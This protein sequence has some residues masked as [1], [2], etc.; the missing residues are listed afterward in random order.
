MALRHPV[1]T[2]SWAQFGDGE[3]KV[4]SRVAP[5]RKVEFARGVSTR[6]FLAAVA[7]H[8]D[9]LVSAACGAGKSVHLPVT[10]VKE[11]GYKFVI[12]VVP[13]RNLAGWTARYV[14]SLPEY[15]GVPIR[16]VE[17][18]ELPEARTGLMIMSAVQ[19]VWLITKWREC[20]YPD[21][22]HVTYMDESHESDWVTCTLRNLRTQVPGCRKFLM[23][24]A[25]HGHGGAGQAFSEPVL[26]SKITVKKFVPEDPMLWDVLQPGKPWSVD[27]VD[28]G[29]AIYIDDDRVANVVRDKYKDAGYR[30]FRLNAHT[31][32]ASFEEAVL[33]Y[34]NT[35]G[36]KAVVVIVFDYSYRN[37][38]TFPGLGLI[39]D[40][41]VVR[42]VRV[43]S[44]STFEW[45]DRHAYAPEVMQTCHRGARVAGQPCVYWRPEYEPKFVVTDLEGAEGDPAVILFRMLGFRPPR[46]LETSPYTNGG[47]PAGC[48]EALKGGTP[49]RLLH[50]RRQPWPGSPE[51][52]SPEKGVA[53]HY[54]ATPQPV[55][56]PSSPIITAESVAAAAA[57][58][59]AAY[60]ARE[61]LEAAAKKRREAAA[62]SRRARSASP[63]RVVDA[64]EEKKKKPERE[65]PTDSGIDVS[66][67]LDQMFDMLTVSTDARVKNEM[68]L[69]KYYY[70]PQ[71]EASPGG[72]R[73]FSEV[74]AVWGKS[75]WQTL[76]YA[77]S[78]T[79]LNVGSHAL[80]AFNQASLLTNVATFVVKK[81]KR[82]SSSASPQV[83]HAI[84]GWVM[85]LKNK[86]SVARA[87]AA[88]GVLALDVLGTIAQE[89]NAWVAKE[90]ALTTKFVAELADA[91]QVVHRDVEAHQA[92]ARGV[93]TAPVP[94]LTAPVGNGGGRYVLDLQHG[95]MRERMAGWILGP[96]ARPV[97]SVVGPSVPQIA[98]GPAYVPAVA[99]VPRSH[100]GPCTGVGTNCK[101]CLKRRFSN[102]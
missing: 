40:T 91:I 5:A 51:A 31:P 98:Y 58:Q 74:M 52:I 44:D 68:V 30:A 12:H 21:V 72:Y 90:E 63:R 73:T 27:Q 77:D 65:G 85:D 66:D 46:F 11:G 45:V 95:G 29:T 47:L 3:G 7:A 18:E 13:A 36:R 1:P 33:Q 70:F 32:Y 19:Y 4:V 100:S 84:S 62:A 88:A 23:A 80:R 87:E 6:E 54:P 89:C 8:D 35:G 61:E 25:S 79:K 20:G 43:S 93:A 49:L 39:I 16:F 10:L 76:D 82:V 48:P 57:A 97:G 71:A 17:N 42:C 96:D 9:L 38:Y 34:Q 26:P 60:L 83:K 75:E 41:C 28:R 24:S 69:G 2:F 81:A 99:G 53:T 94:M 50:R 22:E 86:V 37:G 15:E 102:G 101:G 92:Y 67:A 59:E 64:D 55:M 14:R 78:A 56:R